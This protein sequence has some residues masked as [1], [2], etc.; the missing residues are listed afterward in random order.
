MEKP[1]FPLVLA[2]I[3]GI[4][5]AYYF[6]LPVAFTLMLLVFFLC[7]FIYSIILE[8]SI[9]Y[10]LLLLVFTL[11]ILITI[12]NKSSL[13]DYIDERIECVGTVDQVMSVNSDNG[14]YVVKV[15]N[16]NNK[17]IDIE[18]IM[19]TIISKKDLELGDVI[20][21]NGV[22][23]E[24]MENTNPKLYNYKLNLLSEKIY[25][26]MTIK[27][28]QIRKIDNVK[29]YRYMVKDS[30]TKHVET[31]FQTYLNENNSKLMISIILGK[32]SYIDE[33]NLVLYR[34]L[35]LAHILA[36]SG[37][38]IGILSGFLIF[39]FSRLGIKRR[40][41]IAITLS[42]IW[43]YG[44]LIG[45]PPSILRA[46]IMFSLLFYSS[47][48]YEPYDSINTISFACFLLLLINP[49]YS[50][51]IGFQLSFM[52]AF[53]IVFLTPYI[54]ELFYPYKNKVT[55][56]IAA[57]L[58]VNIG[59]LPIQAYYFN[60]IG[61]LSILAN[62]IL[63]PIF[64]I[65]LIIG[66]IMIVISYTLSFLNIIIGAILNLILSLQNYILLIIPSTV[67]KFYS[68]DLIV[69]VLYFLFIAIVLKVID[70]GKYQKPIRKVIM[71]YLVFLIM[72]NSIILMGDKS[73]ELHFIDVGQG[74]SILIR[75]KDGDYLMDTGGSPMESAFD[76]SKNITL[77]YLEKM[78]I[79]R[80]RAIIIT[81]FH[82]DHSQ[83]LPILVENLKVDNIVASYM[84]KNTELPI[85]LVGQ[86]DEIMLDQ[87]TKLTVIWR[88]KTTSNN[89][90]NMSLVSLLS[91]YSNDVLFTG[92]IE[93]EVEQLVADKVSNS[94]EI[95]K[96]PHH[97]SNT[98]STENFLNLLQPKVGIISVGRNNFYNH[99]SAEVLTS[100]NEINSKI[101]RTDEDGLIKISFDRDNYKITSFIKDHKINLLEALKHN[102]LVVC[103]SLF[104]CS[105]SFIM[106]KI[107]IKDKKELN[108]IDLQ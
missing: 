70:I 93:R 75:T 42:I 88:D 20:S 77:P 63:V 96:V 33:D 27:D 105:L 40:I 35:G 56:T 83:G 1:F 81:H 104:Y 28:Y 79:S 102:I 108:T 22:L 65:S 55:T 47:S 107:Y 92:D 71:I 37:L 58:A 89:E 34:D 90:N 39:L 106:I 76:I 64:S 25:T 67:I 12:V 32:S 54:R 43:F 41:N 100:Y 13:V 17:G 62:L 78:G 74:D 99:P 91:Y 36:V 46:S 15:N 50:F 7:V 52:A 80:L 84:P 24:P 14:R 30:F 26:I 60:R 94:I 85:V 66:F 23:K 9:R 53:S 87:N 57:L 45:Y 73:I 69:I 61:I 21:F 29:S 16:I 44:F 51:H 5:S 3:L 86:G 4:I 68:P 8:K 10:T 97:G 48:I 72:I 95:I 2:L 6:Q 18:K 11:G 31:L 82:A 19:L 101:Y 103:Y 59:L 98:S 38:H 49:Y